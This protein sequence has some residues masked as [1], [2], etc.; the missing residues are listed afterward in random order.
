MLGIVYYFYIHIWLCWFFFSNI[1]QDDKAIKPLSMLDI[2]ASVL[3]E[4]LCD[5]GIK[6]YHATKKKINFTLTKHIIL[7]FIL[8]MSIMVSGMW[9][10][11]CMELSYFHGN[12]VS[13]QSSTVFFFLYFEEDSDFF[14]LQQS[15]KAYIFSIHYCHFCLTIAFFLVLSFVCIPPKVQI[16]VKQNTVVLPLIFISS[17]KCKLKNVMNFTFLASSFDFLSIFRQ[18]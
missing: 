8:R 18:I 10:A 9:V 13:L 3:V 1:Q 2:T 14:C 7:L 5:N 4:W 17:F 12:F 16:I 6:N 11:F 15:N